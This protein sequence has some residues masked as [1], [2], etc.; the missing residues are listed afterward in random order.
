M[1]P[2]PELTCLGCRALHRAGQGPQTPQP[3]R[4]ASAPWQSQPLSPLPKDK[5]RKPSTGLVPPL[6]YLAAGHKA[7]PPSI[8][9][10]SCRPPAPSP[11]QLTLSSSTALHPFRGKQEEKEAAAS[12]SAAAQPGTAHTQLRGQL[13]VQPQGQVTAKTRGISV[14]STLRFEPS[15][16]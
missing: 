4:G 15:A 10:S 16:R 14:P 5:A 7:S 13:C 11:A 2:T 9:T 8:S 6:R 1:F 12:P 3:S